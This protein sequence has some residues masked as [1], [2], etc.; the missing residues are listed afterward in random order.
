M[1]SIDCSV[2]VPGFPS[3]EIGAWTLVRAY[4][5]TVQ[6]NVVND[7]PKPLLKLN[8][9]AV[10]ESYMG[11]EK[12]QLYQWSDTQIIDTIPANKLVPI[13]FEFTPVYPGLV[14]VAL[15]VTDSTDKAVMAKRKVYSSYEEAPV[16]YWFHVADDTLMEILEKLRI[17]VERGEKI[18]K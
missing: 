17:L 12:P 8:A 10:M 1:I 2:N 15:Y 13:K 16:R 7:G 6:F 18:K 11:Q 5:S 9:R 14:S 3:K 4:K